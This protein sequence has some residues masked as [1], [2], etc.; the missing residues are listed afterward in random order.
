MS[1]NPISRPCDHRLLRAVLAAAVLC[2][3]TQS[4][5]AHEGH[6]PLPS[7]G[8]TLDGRML[9]VSE[10]AVKAIDMRLAKIQLGDVRDSLRVNARIELPF[11]Q[12]AKVATLM[13]GRIES[14]LVQPGQRVTAGQ[15]LANVESLELETL[16]GELLRTSTELN[17]LRKLTT[18]RRGL[19]DRGTIPL[20]LLLQTQSDL[21]HKAAEH[22]IARLRLEGWG[23]SPGNV[24]QVLATQQPIASLDIP[25]PIA[26]IVG[27]IAIRPGQLV[28][29]TEQ[30]F[31]IVELS[32]VYAVGEVPE[33]DAARVAAGMPVEMQVSS[34]PEVTFA[35]TIQY[36]HLHL[37]EPQRTLH[38]VVLLDNPHERLR[39]GMY[40]RM[41]IEVAAASQEILCPLS[42][43]VETEEG[44]FVL[45][46]EG[47]RKFSRQAVKLG[48]RSGDEIVIQSGLFPGQQVV[49]N[50]THLLATMYDSLAQVE[51]P[52]TTGKQDV[53]SGVSTERTTEVVTAAAA[54]VVLP[55]N[56]LAIATSLIEGRLAEILVRPGQAVHAGDALAIVQSQELRNLQLEFLQAR[57]KQEWAD[58]EVERLE[59]LAKVGSVPLNEFWQ[60]Q[61]DSTTLRQTLESL[62]R[63]LSLVGIADN[64]IAQL[65]SHRLVQDASSAGSR[66]SSPII[67]RLTIRAAIDGVVADVFLAPGELV[68]AH[69]KLVEI[70]NT[71]TVWVKALLLEEDAARVES[72][73]AAIA[74]F[75]ADPTLRLT[76]PIIHVGPTFA[77]QERLLSVWIELSNPNGLLRDGMLAHVSI[78]VSAAPAPTVTRAQQP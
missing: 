8:A 36:V 35:G 69:D 56:D 12:Q 58:R 70:Q 16:Q 31:D 62:T 3:P 38:V 6:A 27:P 34:L 4:G 40:G 7:N 49:S 55:T 15:P 23:I 5:W 50:G 11:H 33:S 78:E 42:A 25:S 72:G 66:A 44:A 24:D 46:R 47:E 64:E 45:K 1:S 29:E 77:S 61:T 41:N 60:R 73:N 75:A 32:Q 71:D 10:A 30:L 63:R 26:G 22:E 13:S 37:H 39:P 43:I 9:L 76:G 51:K 68:H 53:T 74:T 54:T 48:A 20:S 17:M 21:D 18:E 19:A 65:R 14:I 59:P 67:D 57:S 28:Q 52:A 2:V